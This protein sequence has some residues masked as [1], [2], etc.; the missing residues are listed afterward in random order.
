MSR[1]ST[2]APEEITADTQTVIDKVGAQL[3]FVPA[4]F[5]TLALN[6]A[7]LDVVMTL[8]TKSPKLL[9][10]KTRH[11]IALAVSHANG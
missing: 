6:P 4:M 8:Q 10:A 3:G 9:D 5:N 7:V 2:P 1:L 11:S